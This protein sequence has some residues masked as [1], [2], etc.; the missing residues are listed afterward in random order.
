MRKNGC[1]SSVERYEVLR[2]GDVENVEKEWEKLRDTVT[3]CTN[4]VR[5]WS[6]MCGWAERKESEAVIVTAAEK[7]QAFEEWLQR[8]V[9][10][11]YERYRAQRAV[12]EHSVKVVKIMADWRLGE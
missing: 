9:G 7:L 1:I 10:D 3:E 5:I 12:V 2:D 4:N 11:S 6:G 8:R